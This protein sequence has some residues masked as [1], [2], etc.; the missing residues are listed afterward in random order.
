M[1]CMILEH[2]KW[3]MKI[4]WRWGRGDKVAEEHNA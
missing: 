1:E 4:S 3:D 2:Q